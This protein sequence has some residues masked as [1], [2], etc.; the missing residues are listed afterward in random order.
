MD[1]RPKVAMIEFYLDATSGVP[2]YPCSSSSRSSAP[3]AWAGSE[4]RRPLALQPDETAGVLEERESS[5]QGIREGALATDADG[6]I[7]L[8]NEEVRRLLGLEPDCV[9]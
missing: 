7:T 5:L 6:R 3:C 4:D 1:S 8:A 2:A 9:G